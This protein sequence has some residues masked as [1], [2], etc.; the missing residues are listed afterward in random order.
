MAGQK[1]T[2]LCE[3]GCGQLTNIAPRSRYRNGVLVVRKGDPTRFI[4]HH[5]GPAAAAANRTHGITHRPTWN[6]W[7][8]MIQR[9]HREWHQAWKN[10]GGRGIK[11]CERWRVFANFYADMGERPDG[12]TLDRI[13]NNG[14]YEPGNCRWATPMEQHANRRDNRLITYNGRTQT[15]RAWERE[16]LNGTRTLLG[17][18]ERGWTIQDALT[19]P[20]QR[21][22]RRGSS[23]QDARS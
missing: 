10:Y 4:E 13:D 14:D 2:K 16:F 11:V 9:C 6:T 17:R 7:T 21:K 1:S 3:C 23:A 15:V 18:L 20:V 5:A 8:G 22:R 12:M 19:T